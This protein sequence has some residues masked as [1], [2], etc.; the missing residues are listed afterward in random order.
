M[1]YTIE[2]IKAMKTELNT[3]EESVLDYIESKWGSCDDPKDIILEVLEY[4]CQSGIVSELI[5]YSDTTKYFEAHKDEI[6]KLLIELMK[7]CG[8]KSPSELFGK[9]WDEEDMFCENYYNQNLLAWFGF[10][11]TMYRIASQFEEFE[12]KI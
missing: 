3:L 6:V 2:N 11:E 7:E 9:N 8:V 5:Y 4:G 12:G 1:K 10:E